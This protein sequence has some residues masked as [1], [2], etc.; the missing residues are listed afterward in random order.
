MNGEIEVVYNDAD[1][2]LLKQAKDN[3][4][5]YEKTLMQ[6]LKKDHVLTYQSGNDV[7]TAFLNDRNRQMLLKSIVDMKSIMIPTYKI[8]LG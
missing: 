4:E 6:I 7:L 3:L 1:L 8:K 5:N 2:A